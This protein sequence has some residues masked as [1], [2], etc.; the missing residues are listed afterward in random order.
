MS[1]S[2]RG[3]DTRP[4]RSTATLAGVLAV[5]TALAVG[6]SI[7]DP[8]PVVSAVGGAVL[9]A[10]GAWALGEE[11]NARIA[12]GSVM[13]VAGV[14]GFA[15]TVVLAA[16]GSR[17]AAYLGLALG[18]TYVLLDAV[19][20]SIDD[21]NRLGAALRESGNA[22]LVGIVLAVFLS[23]NAQY[24]VVSGLVLGVTGI[25]SITPL[26]GFVTLQ[27]VAVAVLLLLNRVVPVL[28]GWLPDPGSGDR[29]LETLS[30]VG[31]SRH[32]VPVAAWAVL[33]VESVVALFPQSH[34]LFNAFLVGTPVVG[35]VLRAAL[36]GLL[37]VPLVVIGV[38]LVGILLVSGLQRWVVDW[39]GDDP[40]TT[41]S[42]QA[43]GIVAVAATVVGTAIL[44]LL[45]VGLFGGN[46][47]VSW[48]I[49]PAAIVLGGLVTAA[50]LVGV[51]VTV[52]PMLSQRGFLPQPAGGFA[53]GSAVLFLTILLG[54]ELGVPTVVVIA[55]AAATLLVWDAGAHASSIGAQL[56]RAAG[57]TDSEFVHVTGTGI[58]LGLAVVGAVAARYLVVPAIA[59]PETS[60]AAFRSAVSL[61][62]IVLAILALGLALSVRSDT[63]IAE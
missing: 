25:A 45:G 7:G 24:S 62:L 51:L 58:V 60:A 20:E 27:I 41:L 55:G 6:V 48:V 15:L 63:P 50:L 49:G 33:G 37:H 47:A 2:E 17:L 5:V 34:V 54:A 32:E 1:D 4:V 28:E 38:G 42:L 10:G 3:I 8:L 21:E 14:V 53:L 36:S 43:G 19:T 57:T 61:F 31:L 23:I 22:L 39:L 18:T 35:P 26:V 30:D 56:G 44:P 11:S 59:P 13:A 29:P 46:T 16:G 52:V 40:A 9:I 12:A